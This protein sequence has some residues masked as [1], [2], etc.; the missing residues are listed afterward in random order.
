MG[1][2]PSVLAISWGQ[3][4]RKKDAV[5]AIHMDPEGRVREHLKVDNLEDSED[6]DLFTKMVDRRKPDVIVVGGFS[7]R[8]RELFDRVSRLVNGD[9][10]PVVFGS[11]T[12]AAPTTSSQ[13]SQAASAGA[14]AWDAPT[15]GWD[16]TAATGGWGQTQPAQTENS[17]GGT[18]ATSWGGTDNAWG[19][20]ATPAAD[21]WGTAG[22]WGS[23]AV[24]GEK[25]AASSERKTGK[26]DKPESGTKAVPVIYVND[27]VARIFQHSKRAEDEYGIYPILARYCV[28]LARYVQSPLNEYAAIGTHITALT[29]DDTQP[30]VSNC[31][32]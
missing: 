23:S 5:H 11:N 30:M 9:A 15:S 2:I 22:A 20:T 18:A 8:T 26:E 4:D 17:W 32:P 1:E 12:A 3:G 13:P 24:D 7:L 25:M 29:F 27:E 16:Q 19:A 21:A 28:D 31:G 6:A 10:T 14:G